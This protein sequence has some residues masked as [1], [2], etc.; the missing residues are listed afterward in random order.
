MHIRFRIYTEYRPNIEPLTADRFEGATFYD[1]LGLWRGQFEQSGV[2]EIIGT[3]EDRTKVLD[4]ANVIKT[5]NAQTAILVTVET[6]E[7]HIL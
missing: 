2:I 7:A 1:A 4:L 3:D 5:E 6:V